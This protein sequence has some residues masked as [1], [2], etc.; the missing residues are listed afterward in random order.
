MDEL[1]KIQE[2]YK[3]YKT[4]H[5]ELNS[6]Y[7]FLRKHWLSCNDNGANT[8]QMLLR[9]NLHAMNEEMRR[10][11]SDNMKFQIRINGTSNVKNFLSENFKKNV[12]ILFFEHPNI[13]GTYS[14]YTY[15]TN[16]LIEFIKY[17]KLKRKNGKFSLFLRNEFA[18]LNINRDG[19]LFG[20]VWK[21]LN[22]I[23]KHTD[24]QNIIDLIESFIPEN[25][26]LARIIITQKV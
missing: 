18:G 23:L 7:D 3:E 13:R 8:Y 15:F 6:E 1:S 19:E 26:E 20:W 14:D 24:S 22:K 11:L 25:M 10:Y 2:K 21:N 16:S 4:K 5:D 17:F 12:N 9:N